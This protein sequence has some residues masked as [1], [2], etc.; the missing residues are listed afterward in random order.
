MSQAVTLTEAET[1]YRDF[2][3]QSY[4]YDTLDPCGEAIP[5]GG[6]WARLG[7][8]HDTR[9][10]AAQLCCSMEGYL[11]MRDG[12]VCLFFAEINPVVLDTSYLHLRDLGY[13]LT[14]EEAIDVIR[15]AASY[16]QT[17]PVCSDETLTWLGLTR[18]WLEDPLP[19]FAFATEMDASCLAMLLRYHAGF[20]SHGWPKLA[21]EIW[22][23]LTEFPIDE[24]GDRV[25]PKP[26][27][28]R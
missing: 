23:L 19:D 22:P 28:R 26:A 24:E 16:R 12:Q 15:L 2:D 5:T 11:W 27:K 7:E 20:E 8:G 25:V 10:L 4:W 1:L 14:K 13:Q 3:W 21:C 9:F 17:P 18:H 6:P